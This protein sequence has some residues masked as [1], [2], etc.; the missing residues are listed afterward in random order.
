MPKTKQ[1]LNKKSTEPFFTL[2]SMIYLF[3]TIFFVFLIYS[4]SLPRPWLPF[5]E[6]SFYKEVLF[7]IPTRFDELKEIINAFS[8]NYHI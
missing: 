6:R 4:F 1:T 3:S 5:D 2:E 7:P 8:L